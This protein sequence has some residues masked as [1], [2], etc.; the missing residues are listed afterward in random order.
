MSASDLAARIAQ[1]I[2]RQGPISVAAFMTL[3]LHDA[4][5]GYYARRDP[6]G[7][8]GDFI[9]APE[10][11]QIFGELIGLWYADLWQRIGAP[12][13]LLLAELGP[14]HGTLMADLLRAAET[15]PAFRRALRL[16]LVEASPIL[17]AEQRERLASAEPLFFDD[18]DQ[19]PPGSLLLI[20]NEFLDALPI[21]Q[22]VRGCSEWAERLVGLDADGRLAFVLGPENRALTLLVPPSLRGLSTGTIVEICPAAAALAARLGERFAHSPGAALFIDYGYFPSAPGSTL[23]AARQHRPEHILKNIGAADL[24]AHVDFAAFAEAARRTGTVVWGPVPQG[25]FLVSLGAEARLAALSARASPPQRALL[26]SGLR[27]LIDP[28]EMGTL[29]KAMAVT[30]PG[31]PAPVGFAETA[32]G[33]T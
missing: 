2:R 25:R 27:R 15:V 16:C 28:Q 32:S 23:S 12:E 5:G 18:I 30:S 3:A 14:G 9:T 21:R 20:A 19:L 7:R 17:R 33:S 29:F 22:L 26:E 8:R 24:S 31:L 11:S 4:Q 10:I 6:L 1:N 13:P